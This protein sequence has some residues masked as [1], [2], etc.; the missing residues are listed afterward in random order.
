MTTQ[1]SSET[2]AWND[3]FV[4][5]HEQVDSQH[6][7]LFLL[8][9]DVHSA[10]YQQD[11]IS[12]VSE[13]LKKLIDY[14]QFH[15]R[16]EE[17]LMEELN[18]PGFEDHKKLHDALINKVEDLLEELQEGEVVLV[19]ELLLLLKDWLCEHIIKQDMQIGEFIKQYSW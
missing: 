14:T 1:I 3:S 19:E 4:V 9:K 8:L 13:T 18:F 11:G 6:R 17:Q 15:F 16:D 5:G 7:E 2:F 12:I 10:V